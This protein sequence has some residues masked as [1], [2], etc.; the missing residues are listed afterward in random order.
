[1]TNYIDPTTNAPDF[2]QFVI[3]LRDR[4]TRKT[5]LADTTRRELEAD[6]RPVV[7]Y[8][9]GTEEPIR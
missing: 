8:T 9:L 7:L 5:K 6:T 3:D 1:M 4:F 2:D